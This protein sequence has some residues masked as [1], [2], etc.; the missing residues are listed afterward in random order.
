MPRDVSLEQLYQGCM[1]HNQFVTNTTNGMIMQ[2]S[3]ALR[4]RK[5]SLFTKAG[6]YKNSPVKNGAQAQETVEE[7][8]TDLDIAAASLQQLQASKDIV[9]A[10]AKPCENSDDHGTREKE[11]TDNGSNTKDVDVE[12]DAI[13]DNEK[14]VAAIASNAKGTHVADNKQ[15]EE[16]CKD[17]EANSEPE[18]KL[19]DERDKRNAHKEPVEYC[20][21]L[22][23]VTAIINDIITVITTGSGHVLEVK[24]NNPTL[25][26]EAMVAVQSG[27][28][29]HFTSLLKDIFSLKVLQV[30]INC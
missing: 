30:K 25:E 14:E 19:H 28:S 16:Q 9:P 13:V 26:R 6:V 27:H 29:P 15:L 3:L 8:N 5:T 2:R 17:L 24:N 10:T 18:N 20:S 12:A 22:E 11:Q 1:S 4:E 21:M 23:I 7:D